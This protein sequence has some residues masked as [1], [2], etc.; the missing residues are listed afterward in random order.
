MVHIKHTV[1]G[2]NLAKTLAEQGYRIFNTE[3]ARIVGDSLGIK[4]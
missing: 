4:E 2:V 1:Q 3:V